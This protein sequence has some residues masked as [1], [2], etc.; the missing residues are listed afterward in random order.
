MQLP[1]GVYLDIHT[2]G[3]GGSSIRTNTQLYVAN[4]KLY[5]ITLLKT[6]PCMIFQRQCIHRTQTKNHLPIVKPI[7]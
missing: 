2:K 3:I 5:D 4:N 6:L 1:K 7:N